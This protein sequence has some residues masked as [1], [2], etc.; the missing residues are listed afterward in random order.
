MRHGSAAHA[1]YG[2]AT[3]PLACGEVM[4]TPLS[5]SQA[6]A[7]SVLATDVDEEGLAELAA[8]GI[9]NRV[10]DVTKYLTKNCIRDRNGKKVLPKNVV[11]IFTF[12]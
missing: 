1:T 3:L 9:R 8:Q 6:H 2:A 12:R 7:L 10:L 11:S 4:H 5:T